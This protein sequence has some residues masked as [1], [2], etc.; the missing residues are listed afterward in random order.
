LDA[1]RV[2]LEWCK[3]L[4]CNYVCSGKEEMPMHLIATYDNYWKNDDDLNSFWKLMGRSG[5]H[6]QFPGRPACSCIGDKQASKVRCSGA[7]RRFLFFTKTQK[8]KSKKYVG[9]TSSGIGIPQRTL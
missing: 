5:P 6:F 7:I 4:N 8:R 1:A 9:W 3:Y 2:G